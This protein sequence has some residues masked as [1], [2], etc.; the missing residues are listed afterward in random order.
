MRQT[1]RQCSAY[2]RIINYNNGSFSKNENATARVGNCVL[3]AKCNTTRE[4]ERSLKEAR[5][6]W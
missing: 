4:N 1:R 3:I 6:N 2:S 5:E